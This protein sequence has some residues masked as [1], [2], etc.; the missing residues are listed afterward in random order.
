MRARRK[1]RSSRLVTADRSQRA[2]VD[3]ERPT[4]CKLEPRFRTQKKKKTN[5]DAMTVTFRKYVCDRHA[6]LQFSLCRYRYYLHDN[7]REELGK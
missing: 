4:F 6:E 7:V 1:R 5:R 2:H 3:V